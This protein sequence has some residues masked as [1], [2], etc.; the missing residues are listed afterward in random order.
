[1]QQVWP[2]AFQVKMFLHIPVQIDMS[3]TSSMFEHHNTLQV[4]CDF[5][6]AFQVTYQYVIHG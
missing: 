4:C 6:F 5:L 3:T 2:T 1:M